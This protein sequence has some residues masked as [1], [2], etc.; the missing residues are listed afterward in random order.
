M[1][2]T[3]TRIGAC[4]ALLVF[5]SLPGRHPCA[6]AEPPNADFCAVPEELLVDN[7][8]L[9][10]TAARLR[11]GGPVTIVAIGG[12]ST[13][14]ASPREQ[15]YPA[16]LQAELS[17]RYP[18]VAFS[19]IN[20]GIARQSAA[21]MVGRFASDVLPLHPVLV[22]WETGTNEAA[23]GADLDDFGQT[24][25]DGLALLAAHDID[26]ILVDMQYSRNSSLV[27]NYDPYLEVMRNVA[28]VD[29][30]RMF[31]RYDIMKYWDENGIMD[32][33]AASGQRMLL[34]RQTYACIARRMADVI[35]RATQ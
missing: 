31:R 33:D 15:A 28:D 11:E 32:F 20:K 17:R 10:R 8:Q 12:G 9:P 2:A 14:G 30:I 19:V 4:A 22:I 7:D 1:T 24:L 26:V 34:A 16:R 21:D 18:N 23:R 13:A 3:L 35:D 27:I 5:L 6:M 29:H 25:R